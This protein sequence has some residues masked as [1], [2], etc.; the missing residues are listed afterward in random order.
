LQLFGFTKK[1]VGPQLIHGRSPPWDRAGDPIFEQGGRRGY[2]GRF[3]GQTQRLR[4]V[5][6]DEWAGPVPA[7][8]L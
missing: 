5:Y 3:A 6:A 1:A 4:P 7:I 2:S 8:P